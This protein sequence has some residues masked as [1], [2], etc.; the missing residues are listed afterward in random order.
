MCALRSCFW[1]KASGRCCLRQTCVK[2][3]GNET[4]AIFCLLE[5][6]VHV[7]CCLSLR[8]LPIYSNSTYPNFT[9]VNIPKYLGVAAVALEEGRSAELKV[10]R[11]LS[12]VKACVALMSPPPDAILLSFDRHVT[13]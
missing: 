8:L 5:L 13:P 2:I 10:G 12:F 6:A 9:R 11:P 1:R 4:I 7:S 3:T